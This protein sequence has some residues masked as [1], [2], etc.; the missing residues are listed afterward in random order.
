MVEDDPKKAI[1]SIVIPSFFSLFCLTLNGLVDSV[2]VAECGSTSLIGV[3][4][5]QSIFVIVVGIGTGLSVSTNS[6][7]SYTISKYSTKDHA[8]RIIDN[9]IVLTLMIGIISSVLLVTFLKPILIALN[10][11]NALEPA[12]IY[13]TVLFSG[14]IFFFFAA[15]IPSILKAEGEVLKATYSFIST[16][17]LN[18]FLD[19]LLIHVLG[20]GVFGAACATMFCSALCCMMLVYFM[21]KSKNINFSVSNISNID[22]GLM[23]K[24]FTDSI[25]VA[26]ECGILSLFSFFANMLFNYFT[27]PADFAAFIASYKVYNMAIIPAIALAEAN[28]TVVAYLYGIGD[29]NTMNDLLKYEFKIISIITLALFALIT[30]FR[31]PIAYV[32]SISNPQAL[33][34]S[35]AVALPLLNIILLIMPFGILSV[36]VL[37]GVQAYKESFIVSTIRSILLEIVLGFIFAYV[38]ADAFGI[39]L[40][41]I[42]GAAL[43]CALSFYITRKIID[44]RRNAESEGN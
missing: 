22:F 11:G 10:I 33:I 28:V 24:L 25:P 44:K 18:I 26:F 13:G 35:I 38:M 42:L 19:Y 36:S 5:I 31:Y 4:V 32:Y 34:D 14:N 6:T 40:G 15:V 27:N 9:S 7:L 3:G 20:Y 37:Q 21:V 16:S 41:F 12:L 8:K 17:L 23:K 43:G 1:R 29:F 30:L 2:F 39:Y